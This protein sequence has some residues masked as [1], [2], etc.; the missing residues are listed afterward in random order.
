[1]HTREERNRMFQEPVNRQNLNREHK[2]RAIIPISFFKCKATN[3][4]N[5]VPTLPCCKHPLCTD[6][7]I[8]CNCVTT[9]SNSQPSSPLAYPSFLLQRCYFLCYAVNSFVAAEK[10]GLFYPSSWKWGGSIKQVS[11]CDISG[12]E[13]PIAVSVSRGRTLKSHFKHYRYLLYD[14]SEHMHCIRYFHWTK[15][16]I[17]YL[18]SVSW[19]TYNWWLACPTCITHQVELL[20]F[21]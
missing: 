8:Y 13:A 15:A 4:G 20:D 12:H 10:K 2:Q 1:M 18:R 3:T 16:R 6:V 17:V 14:E 7:N 5:A 21:K 9:P 11:K 19:V